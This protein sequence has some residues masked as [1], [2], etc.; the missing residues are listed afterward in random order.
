MIDGY[1][2]CDLVIDDHRYEC[3]VFQLSYLP[4]KRGSLRVKLNG[5]LLSQKRRDYR[6]RNGDTVILRRPRK[7]T[8]TFEMRYRFVP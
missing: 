5:R 7:L 8:D 4:I 2:S 1:F 3:Q 6:V